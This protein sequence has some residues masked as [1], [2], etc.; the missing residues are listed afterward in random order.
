M[1]SFFKKKK[2]EEEEDAF[3]HALPIVADMHNH[4]LPGLDDGAAT[5]EESLEM[6]KGFVNMGFKKITMT[7]HIMH[8][9]YDN[10]TDTIIPA[11]EMMRG[12]VKE[13]GL[14]VELSAAA[15]YYYDEVFFRK[16]SNKEPLLS[17]GDG[18]YVLFETAFPSEPM[19]IKEGIRLIQSQD[20]FPVYAHPERYQYIQNDFNKAKA[21]FATGVLFQINAMSL[22]GQYG[23]APQVIAEKL[24][25]NDM[26]HFIGS[27]CHKP[28]HLIEYQKARRTKHYLKALDSNLYNQYV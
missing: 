5:V 4:L 25:D 22:V 9:F 14:T 11:L 6:I 8:N 21:L 19:N 20:I 18:K 27:D 26:V 28:V 16:L 24:I 15:E 2:Q 17:F 23:K 3:F 10:D 12:I 13:A 1:F 7:P